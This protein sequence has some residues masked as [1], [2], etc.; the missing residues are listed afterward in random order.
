MKCLVTGATGHIGNVLVRLLSER[1]DIVSAYCLEHEDTSA[2]APYVTTI[3][4]GD[5]R[6]V[7]ALHIGCL[8]QDVVFHLAG[9]IDI[10]SSHKAKRQMQEVNVEGTQSVL[11]CCKE[12]SVKRLVYVSSVHA[13][14]EKPLGTII[15]EATEFNPLW[16]K[17]YYAKT[18][19][20]ATSLVLQAQSSSLD[21]IVVHPSGVIGPDDYHLSNT[22]QLIL[23]Y[24][25]GSMRVY[26]AGGY[27][28]VDV[29]D[30]SQ[31]II[32]AALYGLSGQ[33][34]ILSGHYCSVKELLL[35]LTTLRKKPTRL[36][37]IPRWMVYIVTPFFALFYRITKQK[38]LFT[39]YSLYT[40]VSNSAFS[41]QKAQ[42][43]LGYTSRPLIQTLSDTVKWYLARYPIHP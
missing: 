24:L 4:Y 27:N 20:E 42:H 10:T 23:N 1:G 17:G 37:W 40:L 22:G 26:I 21:V 34:Y 36:T 3:H 29:R 8:G 39:P 13:I 11:Q 7:S 31:G 9:V 32:N 14:R 30:V 2:I 28:F 35:A 41:S 19:A 16:V 15:E 25:E 38:P 6:D 5:I 33:C 18:K 12:S 43:Q